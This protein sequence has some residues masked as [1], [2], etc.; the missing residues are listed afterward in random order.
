MNLTH[1]VLFSFI[2]G[3]SAQIVTAVPINYRISVRTKR[4]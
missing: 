4:R 1:L 2:N 3:A